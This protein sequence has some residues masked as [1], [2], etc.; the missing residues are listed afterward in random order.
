MSKKSCEAAES[1]DRCVLRM[2]AAELR[3]KMNV[4]ILSCETKKGD[5][6]KTLSNEE[7]MSFCS[8]LSM[9]LHAGISSIEGL[10]IMKEDLPDGEGKKILE[11]VYEH[12]EMSGNLAQSMKETKV[13]PEYVCNM[14]EIGEQTG[15]LDEVMDGLVL[16]YEREKDL[17][18]SI[19]SALLYPAVMLGMLTVV[20]LILV[21]KVMPVFHEVLQQLGGGLTGVSAGI[22]KI[23]TVL[24][25]YSLVFVVLLAL[26]VAAIA[27][28]GLTE[29]GREAFRG[30]LERSRLTGKTAE[31]IACS[32]VAEGLSLCMFSGLDMDQSLE[33][34]EKLVTHSEMKQRIGK[35]R[36]LM[37]EGKGIDQALTESRIF[38]GIYGKMVSVGMRTGSVDQ[39]MSKIAGEY[40]DDVV[41]SLQHKVS[42]IEPTLVAVLSVLVGLILISVMLPLMNI[43]SSLG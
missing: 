22:L 36:E 30:R 32:R 40:E 31:K 8:Q 16:H 11:A 34:T 18:E 19:K 41:Q 42:V 14:T 17:A 24:S 39:V 29:K 37:M 12:M 5:C 38:S 33:M 21:V 3:R 4:R 23:G 43:M 27:Y 25:R 26:M 28:L 20:I 2:C 1:I 13:F 9:I 15:R 7:L 10:A 35:C 6:M